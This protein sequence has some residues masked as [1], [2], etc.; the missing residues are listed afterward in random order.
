[1]A[2]YQILLAFTA[3][4]CAMLSVAAPALPAPGSLQ[5]VPNYGSNPA[6]VPMFVYVPRAL[7]S[8]PGVVVAIHYCG[9]TAQAYYSGSP[10]AK[11]AEQYGFL[12]VYPSSPH[13]GTC[14][15]VCDMLPLHLV[16]VAGEHH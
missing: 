11:L 5:P 6:G 7:A 12:I 15:D 8:K 3:L 2:T 1:M 4:Y 13:S 14:W 16:S 10:Y 9:G